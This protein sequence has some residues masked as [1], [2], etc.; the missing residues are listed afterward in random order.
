[1]KKRFALVCVLCSSALFAGCPLGTDFVPGN[2]IP[3]GTPIPAELTGVWRAILTYVP[4]YYTGQ[5]PVNDFSG[6]LGVNFYFGADGQ[7]EHVLNSLTMGS[8]CIRTTQWRESGTLTLAGTA[9]TLHPAQATNSVTD[10]CGPNKYAE[11]A[12]ANTTT[13]TVTPEQDPNGW[14]MLRVVLPSGDVVLMEKGRDCQ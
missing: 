11:P 14:P 12:Q 7:Y 5:I 8:I 10:N 1:M 2:N 6:S 3:A 9:L 4:G 13:L